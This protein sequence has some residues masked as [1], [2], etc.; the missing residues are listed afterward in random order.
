MVTL[1]PS[2]VAKEKCKMKKDFNVLNLVCLI[3]EGDHTRCKT[4]LTSRVGG[5][6][7]FAQKRS[8]CIGCKAVLKTDGWVP[9]HFVSNMNNQ[10]Y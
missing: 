9:F 4:V 6:M 1:A 2:S 3:S 8:T 7:A 5:L 10:G